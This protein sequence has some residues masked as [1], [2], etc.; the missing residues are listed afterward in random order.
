MKQVSQKGSGSFQKFSAPVNLHTRY[1]EIFCSLCCVLR[2][3]S[4]PRSLRL[5]NS[6]AF[7]ENNT[8]KEPKY[9]KAVDRGRLVHLSRA[10]VLTLKGWLILSWVTEISYYS[11]GHGLKRVAS[12]F[13]V[14]S[15]MT[16]STVSFSSNKEETKFIKFDPVG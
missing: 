6:L 7:P 13:L 12:L 11:L 8:G 4:D 9:T 1:C 5:R 10:F 15:H 14:G 3:L 2:K 16:R